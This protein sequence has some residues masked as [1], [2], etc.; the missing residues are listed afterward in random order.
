MEFFKKKSLLAIAVLLAACALFFACGSSTEPV[1][2]SHT[3]VWGGWV[4]VDAATCDA[5]GSEVRHCSAANCS[6]PNGNETRDIPQLTGVSCNHEHIWEWVVTTEATCD[7]Q[8]VRIQK[9][10]A[11]EGC[12]ATND[13]ETFSF[14][15]DCGV[16]LLTA[17]HGDAW[18]EFIGD[19]GII[20]DLI[21]DAEDGTIQWSAEYSELADW[22]SGTWYY[23]AV[24]Y[25]FDQGLLTTDTKIAITYQ[26]TGPV[27]LELGYKD[28]KDGSATRPDNYMTIL[29]ATGDEFSVPKTFTLELGKSGGFW[30]EDDMEGN[31][32]PVSGKNFRIPAWV[33]A[34]MG[35]S[36]EWALNLGNIA[37]LQ[38]NTGASDGWV[39]TN[40][41]KIIDIKLVEAN[42]P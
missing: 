42:W 32:N 5:P 19:D 11:V 20:V 15:G 12:L 21:F 18:V 26:A 41:I 37:S 27:Q 31:G 3:H 34:E 28:G 14:E 24:A 25:F 22:E 2:P 29:P 7:V 6:F 36:A 13:Q 39:V 10:I 30:T 40:W 35:A 1:K 9:C 38:F 33:E 4:Q 8:G 17:D 16:S 23:A